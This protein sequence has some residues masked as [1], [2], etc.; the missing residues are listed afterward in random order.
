[1]SDNPPSPHRCPYCERDIAHES[2]RLDCR[3]VRDIEGIEGYLDIPAFLDV[4][5]PRGGVFD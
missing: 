2:H 1:M 5:K 4:R 3:I